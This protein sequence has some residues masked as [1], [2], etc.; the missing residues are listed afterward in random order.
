MTPEEFAGKY[1][2]KKKEMK[3]IEQKKV[4]KIA[5]TLENIVPFTLKESGLL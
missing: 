1:N 5:T 2:K 3:E 4:M